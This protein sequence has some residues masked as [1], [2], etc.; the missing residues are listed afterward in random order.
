MITAWWIFV[1]FVLG[2]CAGLL[3]TALLR[4]AADQPRDASVPADRRTVRL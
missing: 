2:G 3:L 1:A 4:T